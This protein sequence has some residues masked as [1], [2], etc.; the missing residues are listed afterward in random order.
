MF[1]ILKNDENTLGASLI[2]VW[3]ICTGTVAY[4]ETLKRRWRMDPNSSFNLLHFPFEIIDSTIKLYVTL[5][6]LDVEKHAVIVQEKWETNKLYMKLRADICYQGSSLPRLVIKS[7]WQEILHFS[8]D[9]RQTFSCI[10]ATNMIIYYL[11]QYL[12]GVTPTLP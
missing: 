8:I 12:H 6:A 11:H 9:M 3:T 10:F 1:C 4:H 7:L 2:R 5:C